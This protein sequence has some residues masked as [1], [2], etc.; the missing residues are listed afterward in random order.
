[1]TPPRPKPVSTRR[2]ERAAR[3]VPAWMAL[4]AM[5]AAVL[6]WSAGWPALVVLI[7]SGAPL[8]VYAGLV[9]L[10]YPEAWHAANEFALLRRR[11]AH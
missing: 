7:V 10:L 1:M 3:A 8:L 4:G 11:V 6:H 5:L 9:R 2:A